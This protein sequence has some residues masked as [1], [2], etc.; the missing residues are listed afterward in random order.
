MKTNIFVLIFFF[1]LS[2]HSQ[3]LHLTRNQ[4]PYTLHSTDTINHSALSIGGG[5]LF[6]E[7]R[8]TTYLLFH[9]DINLHTYE[10]LYL[11]FGLNVISDSKD[12]NHEA[13]T[14]QISPNIKSDLFSKRVSFFIGAGL[15]TTIFIFPMLGV[16][17]FAKLQYNIT[18]KLSAGICYYHTIFFINTLNQKSLM[19]PGIY[20]S[21]NL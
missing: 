4:N 5:P 1:S 14:L 16:N 21:L 11:E 17:F 3:E 15:H 7:G 18:P 10:Q 6:E 2:L 8:V 12:L 19:Y 13:F 20:F 9:S